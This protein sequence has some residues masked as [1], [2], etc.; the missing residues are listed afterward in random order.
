MNASRITWSTMLF[1]AALACGAQKAPGQATTQATQLTNV[2]SKRVLVL[3]DVDTDRTA[4]LVASLTAAGNQVPERTPPK[5]EL[6]GVT[7]SPDSFDCIVHLD[8]TTFAQALPQSTQVI[9]DNWV[10]AGGGFVAAQ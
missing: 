6:V 10:K 1:T 3:A 9:L 4:A 7:P 8:G 5:F 2:S